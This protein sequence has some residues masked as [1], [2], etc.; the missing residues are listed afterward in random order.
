MPLIVE[1]G[2]NVAGANSY[3]DVATIVAYAAA[4]GITLT[5]DV[6]ELHSTDAMDYLETQ[7]FA[8]D[9]TY[10]DQALDFPRQN[11]VINGKAIA[12]DKVP[13]A[14]AKAQMELIVA[15]AQGVVLLPIRAAGPAVKMEKLDVIE[16]EYF[17]GNNF[18][19]PYL[20]RVAA[21]LRP[22]LSV[23]SFGLTAIRV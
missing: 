12:S 22:F 6:A 18:V 13:V 14:I 15:R 11:I 20:P 3:T 9:N 10:D 5:N 8:G 23:G 4:R 19:A 21:L 2:S 17:E 1:D 7:S 16:T